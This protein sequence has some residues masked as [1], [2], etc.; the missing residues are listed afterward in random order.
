MSDQNSGHSREEQQARPFNPNEHVVQIKTKDGFRDYLP[1]QWRLVWFR[2]QHPAGSIETEMLHLD[3]DRETEEE[4]DAWSDEKNQYEKVVKHAKGFTVF[5][6]VVKDG[7][8]GVGTGTKSEKAASFP[9]YIEKAETGAIGRALA[10]LG[11]GTQ[12]APELDEEHR[13]VDS[14]V[15]RSVAE[16][17]SS[18]YNAGTGARQSFPARPNTAGNG[19]KASGNGQQ[20]STAENATGASVTEKQLIS[21][22]KLCEYLGKPE[23]ENQSAMSYMKAKELIDQLTLEYRQR[24]SG[25]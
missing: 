18:T 10:A 25:S 4:V 20:T 7:K 12:F 19:N 5:R 3:L 22:R 8:G 17:S 14:P 2:E 16:R 13:I 15:K 11:F 24:R 1:V 6:A 23:P 21:I 9:D